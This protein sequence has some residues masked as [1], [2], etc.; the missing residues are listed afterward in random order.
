MKPCT[1]EELK[2]MRDAVYPVTRPETRQSNETWEAI[3]HNWRK[4]EAWLTDQYNKLKAW[5]RPKK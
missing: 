4:D 3:K 5:E 1:D 2:A